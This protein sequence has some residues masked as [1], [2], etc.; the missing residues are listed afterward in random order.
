MTTEFIRNP[1][2]WKDRKVPEELNEKM[3]TC[4]RCHRSQPESLG[5][6]D[7]C[8]EARQEWIDEQM[9]RDAEL[10]KDDPETRFEE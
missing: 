2:V 1:E 9:E 10:K 7:F 4:P 5:A 8:E 6:C 3:I